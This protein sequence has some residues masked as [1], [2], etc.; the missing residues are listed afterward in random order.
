M[1][2][3]LVAMLLTACGGT[4]KAPDT[5]T[6]REKV[7]HLDP[8]NAKARKEFEDG[9]RALRIGGESS[10]ENAKLKLKAALEIDPKL[11]EAWHDLGAIAFRDGE[12]DVAVDAYTKALA[13]NKAHT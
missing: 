5:T 12:D 10:H 1:K 3:L 13:I 9:M 6:R 2:A 8:V 7:T 4:D 11:W